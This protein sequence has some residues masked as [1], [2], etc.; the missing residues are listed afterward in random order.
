MSPFVMSEKGEQTGKKIW[1]EMM[2]VLR[3][4]APKIDH[5]F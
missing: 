1:D 2:E 3:S 5:I 4:V